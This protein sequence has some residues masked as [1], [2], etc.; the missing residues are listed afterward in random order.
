LDANIQTNGVIGHDNHH[1]E[2]YLLN[3]KNQGFIPADMNSANKR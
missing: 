1:G 2:V 3:E